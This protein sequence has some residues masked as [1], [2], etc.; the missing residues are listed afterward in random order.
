MSPTTLGESPEPSATLRVLS[1]EG[2]STSCACLAPCCSANISGLRSARERDGV[3]AALLDEGARPPR[4][5][6]IS[7][8]TSALDSRAWRND[9]R[10]DDCSRTVVWRMELACSWELRVKLARVLVRTGSSF[11][12]T[13][14]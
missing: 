9:V 14:V 10:V 2:D 1:A 5:P 6:D 11:G 12:T 4:L 7:D 3:S 8:S 13:G